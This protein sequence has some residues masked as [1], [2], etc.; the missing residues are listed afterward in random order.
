MKPAIIRNTALAAVIALLIGGGMIS[1][2]CSSDNDPDAGLYTIWQLHE[3]VLDDGTTVPVDEPAHYTL[4]LRTDGTAVIRSD[5]NNCSS[6]FSADEDTLTFGLMA[7]T[8]A[9]CLPGSFDSQYRMA[10]ST[11]SGY[12]LTP[13]L[14]LD[15]DGG[16]MRFIP[17][18]TLI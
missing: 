13:Q 12:E 6:S 10:L 1:T 9:A 14:L 7:C 16:V 18:P 15:Y 17:A 4:E 11:A 5:C 2:G 3:F 8:L